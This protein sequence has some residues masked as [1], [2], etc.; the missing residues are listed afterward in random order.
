MREIKEKVNQLRELINSANYNYYILDNPTISDA[1]YD[2]LMRELKNLENKYSELITPDSP[3]QRVGAKP[4]SEFNTVVHRIPLLSLDNAMNENEI[5]DFVA[6]TY[7]GLPPGEIVQF[8]C[9][10]KIDGLA[11]ELLYEN[12]FFV[13]GSTRGD[14]VTGEDITQNLKTIRSIPLSLRKGKL[15][16]PSLLEVRGEVYMDREEFK[17]LNE[18]Q[19][20]EGKPPFANPRN[21]AAGSLRQ[22][23]PKV[24]AKRPL[25][26]FCY[27]LGTCEGISFSTHS[28]FL[29]ALPLWGFR[30]NPL[31]E[32]CSSVEEIINY[33]RK[34]ESN[35]KSISYDIDGVVFKVN[36]FAQQETLGIKS[37][38]PR[39]AIAGKFK[40]Q[41]EIT[42]I[43]DIIASTGRTGSITPVAKLNPV[44]VGGVTISNATLHNQDEITRKDIREKDWVVI[45]RAGDVIPQVVKVITERRT[46]EEKP[47]HIPPICPVCGAH[48][49]RD[50]GEAKHYCQNIN[51]P[52]RIKRSIQHFVSKRAMNIDGL[53][54]K[55]VEQLVDEGLIKNVADLYF[56]KKD[57]LVKLERMADKSAQNI[58]DALRKSK[59]T[60]LAKFIYALGIRNV[61]EHMGK[62]LEKSFGTFEKLMSATY[63]ELE[64][65]EGVGPIVAQSIRNF[66]DEKANID[67]IKRLYEGGVKISE[68]I[69]QT[70]EKKFEGKTF[71]FTGTLSTMTRNEAKD[72]VEKF[73]GKASS[74][75]SKKMDYVVVG[76][77]PGSKADKANNLGVKILSE[78]EFK[79]L[80]E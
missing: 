25:N 63:E 54:D 80:L 71:I 72:L 42:Q 69:A 38:S 58:I 56:L 65:I 70:E 32:M 10:P 50:E 79:S 66:F 39:W 21:S 67:T 24:T 75:V 14:G 23:D 20:K 74:S 62:V 9:E 27:S 51:C 4:L 12:G 34:V 40:A 30:V 3:T 36:S 76:E 19:L 46:G 13:S 37:R 17:R 61:G 15:P 47:Y 64:A 78:E 77:N 60:T 68:V 6:R 43:I 45:Q 53:G 7:R 29:K 49:V 35:R 16:I 28:E 73:G 1:E 33:Y 48:V 2:R 41:Q 26:I 18:Q 55:L 11:I 52:A 22:L 57:N 31:I 59:N 8:V 44:E 5:R